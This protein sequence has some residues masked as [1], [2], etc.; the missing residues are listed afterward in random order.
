MNLWDIYAKFYKVLR[1][2]PV[3]KN[4]LLAEHKSLL[5]LLE[6]RTPSSIKGQALDLGTGRGDCLKCIPADIVKIYAIDKSPKMVELTTNRYKHVEVSVGDVCHTP[7]ASNNMDLILCVGVS[8]YIAEIE[9]LVKEISR[10]LNDR[11]F[12]IITSSPPNILNHIRKLSGHRLFLRSSTEM[13]AYLSAA[14]FQIIRITHNLI[15]GQYL[16]SKSG[17]PQTEKG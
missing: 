1:S 5:K 2:N 4:I 14:N 12:A 16:L 3:S 9:T 11:G 10:V 17:V 6:L 13:I 15:Q 7:Y 8:E